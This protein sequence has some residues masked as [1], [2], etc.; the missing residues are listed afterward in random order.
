ML[1]ESEFTPFRVQE[2]TPEPEFLAITGPRLELRPD[3]R[4]KQQAFRT[5]TFDAALAPLLQHEDWANWDLELKN[6]MQD[7]KELQKL[8]ECQ[9]AWAAANAKRKAARLA[10]EEA[11]RENGKSSAGA[12]EG[13]VEVAQGAA[14]EPTAAQHRQEHA[15][16][17]VQ[18]GQHALT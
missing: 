16:A 14:G 10:A 1:T 15:E 6:A 18:A 5:T 17:G 3:G 11:A 7:E 2:N 4:R 13:E 9:A 12:D 8:F